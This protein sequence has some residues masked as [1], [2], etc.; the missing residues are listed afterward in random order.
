M[1]RLWF[2]ENMQM[3]TVRVIELTDEEIW[4]RA[5]CAAISNSKFSPY[6]QNDW[7]CS[8]E[9]CLNEFNER[10]NLNQDE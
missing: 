6:G 4:L 5:Y 2:W 8:A 10:F 1:S 7:K 9:K 3:E